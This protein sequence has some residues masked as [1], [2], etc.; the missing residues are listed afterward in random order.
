MLGRLLILIASTK[1]TRWTHDPLPCFQSSRLGMCSMTNFGHASVSPR[2]VGIS[3]ANALVSRPP[4][5]AA[6]PSNPSST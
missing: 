1:L 5:V 4:A 2:S 6:R 3:V